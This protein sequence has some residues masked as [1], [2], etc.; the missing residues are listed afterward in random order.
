MFIQTFWIVS[1]LTFAPE[2]WRGRLLTFHGVIEA[3]FLML[4][5][6]IF[7]AAFSSCEGPQMWSTEMSVELG[8][9]YT[10]NHVSHKHTFPE[11]WSGTS[12][13]LLTASIYLLNLLLFQIWWRTLMKHPRM[14]LTRGKGDSVECQDLTGPCG[15]Q[16]VFLAISRGGKFSEVPEKMD[17]LSTFW[18]WAFCKKFATLEH[19]T[20]IPLSE[21]F[22]SNFV[23]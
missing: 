14:R 16:D 10:Y 23:E 7:T 15:A 4:Y 13:S 20:C 6:I 5:N 17:N 9:R 1:S 8:S 21:L 12:E 3:N 22:L 2:T 18:L 11:L 19:S